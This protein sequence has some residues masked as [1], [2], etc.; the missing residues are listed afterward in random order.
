M[1][2]SRVSVTV[3]SQACSPRPSRYAMSLVAIA[4]VVV[5]S[6]CST[7]STHGAERRPNIVF[8]LADDK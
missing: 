3:S 5:G 2:V 6:L 1:S 4:L 8:I 7:P